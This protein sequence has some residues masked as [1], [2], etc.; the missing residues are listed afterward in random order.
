[1][2]IYAIAAAVVCDRVSVPCWIV[3]GI[4]LGLA[5]MTVTYVVATRRGYPR[6]RFPGWRM[7]G[8]AFLVALPGLMSAVLIVGGILSGIFTATESSAVAVAYRPL[9]RPRSIAAWTGTHFKGHAQC[10]KDNFDCDADYCVSIGFRV[11]DGGS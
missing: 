8:T 10:R 3:P 11:A 7:V 5:L 4:L 6:G 1:M 2:I 9:S